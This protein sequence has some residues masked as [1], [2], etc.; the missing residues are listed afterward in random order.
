MQV[1]TFRAV[2]TN[3]AGTSITIC[4]PKFFLNPNPSAED[5]DNGKLCG[6]NIESI[7]I[8]GQPSKSL[9]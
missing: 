2:A 5:L 4:D 7:N 8:S 9:L 1:T 3:P 6:S